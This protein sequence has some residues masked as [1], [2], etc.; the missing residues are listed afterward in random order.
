LNINEKLVTLGYKEVIN[1]TFISSNY[2]D[3][4][5]ELKLENPI[6]KEK[7]VMRESLIPG[8][9]SNIT[10]N[11]NR[12]QKS[13][14]IFERGKSY[15]K[16]KSKIKEPNTIS[17]VLYGNKSSIDLV[18]NSYKYGIGDLKS[19]ILSILPDVTFKTGD[20]SIYFDSNN[21]LSLLLRNKIIG[22]CGL[23]SPVVMKDFEIKGNVF[24]FEIMEDSLNQESDVIFTEISQF[25]AVYKD[26]T[27]MTNIDNNIL[28]IIDEIRKDSYKYM[29]NIRIKDI[30]INKDNLQSNNRNVTLEICLQSNSKTLSD[31]DISDD[32][33]KV[34]EDLK[35]IHKI[36][37]QEA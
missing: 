21:S 19:D 17:A 26:I 10:Y 6:S 28:K 32:V 36:R 20:K 27:L 14:K 8:L 2:M 4:K 18:S 15:Y 29:K 23:I 9:L 35:N 13:I 31:K 33:D 7:S 1:F 24:G 37:L 5:R 16:D 25:P 11:A 3:N 22:Q 34:I 30:F 12:K